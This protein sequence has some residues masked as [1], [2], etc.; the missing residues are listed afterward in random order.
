M[1]ALVQNGK[2]GATNTSYPT[3]IGYYVVKFLS[4]PYTLQGGKTVYKQVINTGI[5]IVKS[6]YLSIMNVNKNWYWKKLGTTE[7]VI[8]ETHTI[9][10][11]CL[12]VSTIK[13]VSD[14]P[15]SLC[16]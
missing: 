6:E 16:K 7:S 1:S 3:T 4:E 2:Y 15:R 10:Y 9:F 8:I 12:Y 13:N 5:I 14:I 11:P